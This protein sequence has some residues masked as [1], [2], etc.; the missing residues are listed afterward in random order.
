M[1]YFLVARTIKKKNMYEFLSPVVVTPQNRTKSKYKTKLYEKQPM[2]LYLGRLE[3]ADSHIV[4]TEKGNTEYAHTIKSEP[5]MYLETQ[6]AYIR[7]LDEAPKPNAVIQ[8]IYNETS[9]SPLFN[10][11]H[12]A[13]T[14]SVGSTTRFNRLSGP[15]QKVKK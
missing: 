15:A 14:R 9:I 6:L 2:G 11:F 1:K 7:E 10:P 13:A 4:L 3:K 5:E 12:T 8:K